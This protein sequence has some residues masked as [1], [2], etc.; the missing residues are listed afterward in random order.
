MIA[1]SLEIPELFVESDSDLHTIRHLLARHGIPL[2]EDL[3]PV[4]IKNGGKGKNA[5]GVLDA[6]RNASRASMNRPVGFVIDANGD[7][8][9]RWQ[10]VRDRLQE[11]NIELPATAPAAGFVGFGRSARAKIGVWIMPDNV[12]DSGKLENLVR[13][14]VPA[15]DQLIGHAVS[16][17]SSA[18]E[19]G[20]AFPNQDRIKAELHCWLAWQREP[21]M[22]FG[23]A[24]KARLL[25]HD[26][27]AANRFVRWFR[28]LY[29]IM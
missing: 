4:I 11:L 26:S 16:A 24:L 5:Q 10:A 28:S 25:R 17:T 21:G 13:T 23:M 18:I 22:P 19:K 7:V 15:E 2:D 29:D 6:M 12:T 1:P 14:L 20:A 8:A 3:G 27:D 9:H